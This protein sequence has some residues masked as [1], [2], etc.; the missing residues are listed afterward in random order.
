MGK[1]F[2]SNRNYFQLF[3]LQANTFPLCFFETTGLTVCR[4]RTLRLYGNALYIDQ[5]IK[6]RIILLKSVNNSSR[7]SPRLIVTILRRLYCISLQ[8]YAILYRCTEHVTVCFGNNWS[9]LVF[10]CTKTF[11]YPKHGFYLFEDIISR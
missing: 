8:L 7:N 5:M 10:G 4:Q 2:R 6:P 3:L 11:I 9:F 1:L